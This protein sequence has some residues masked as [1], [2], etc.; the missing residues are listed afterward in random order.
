LGHA[1]EFQQAEMHQNSDGGG[2]PPSTEADNNE[3]KT[4]N[5]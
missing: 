5:G 3:A 2:E 1:E 4:T